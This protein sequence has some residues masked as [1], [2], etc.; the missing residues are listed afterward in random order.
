MCEIPSFAVPA[1]LKQHFLRMNDGRQIHVAEVGQGHPLVFV[2]GWPEFW[3][4]WLPVVNLLKSNYRCI[5][6]CLYGFGLSDKPDKINNSID[7]DF[8]ASDINFIVKKLSSNRPILIGHDVGSYVLQSI[9][10]KTPKDFSGLIFFNCPTASVGR[11]WVNDGH[12]N[13]IWYQS[14]HLTDLALKL[15]GFNQDTIR[16]YI[17]Y[18]LKHWS[19]NKSAFE[20]VLDDWVENFSQPNALIGGF[21]WYK[22]TNH[23]NV[24]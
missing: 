4:S 8:H 13:E 18:F 1:D 11:A 22:R 17:E 19:Y 12:V 23:F 14:F 24:R 3:K 5:M 7:A 6:P 10:H 21:S 9:G 16:L 2:H 20:L 15:V